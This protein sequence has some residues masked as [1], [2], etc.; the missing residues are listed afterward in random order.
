MT[1]MFLYT[2][3][4]AE[5][6]FADEEDDGARVPAGEQLVEM[7][8]GVRLLVQRDGKGGATVSR[9]LSTDP[10]DFLDARWQPGNRVWG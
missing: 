1:L 9:L 2:I 6:I 10:Q 7:A 4:P 3:V 8:G 5:I